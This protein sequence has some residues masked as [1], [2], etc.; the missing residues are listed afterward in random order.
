MYIRNSGPEGNSITLSSLPPSSKFL[1]IVVFSIFY[2]LYAFESLKELSFS[3]LF[4]T[5]LLLIAA[6]TK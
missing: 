2:G 6:N 1:L 4:V 3:I 5:E